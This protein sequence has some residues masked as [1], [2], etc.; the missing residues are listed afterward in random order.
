MRLRILLFVIL[1]AWIN[2]YSQTVYE[3]VSSDIYALLERLYIRGAIEYHSE[4]KP[5]PR[6]EIA[7]YL[8]E[9]ITHKNKLTPLDVKEI[10]FYSQEFADEI[11]F[12][13][14]TSHLQLPRTEFFTSGETGRFRLFNYMDSSFSFNLDPILGIDVASYFNSGYSH[15]WNG[16]KFFGYISDHWGY[17]LDFRDN[18]ES[19]TNIDIIKS[20]TPE[21]GINLT[22]LADK[23]IQYDEVNAE[24]N[25]GWS[26]GNV[27][28]G[29]YHLNIG[30]GRAGQIIMSSKAPSFPMVRL[31]IRPVKW[32]NFIYFHGWLKSDIPDSSTF[33]YTSVKGR[34]SISDVPKFIASHM[35]SFYIAEDLS[36]SIGESVVY[37]GKVEPIY[38][39]PVMFFR[40]ADHYLSSTGS[41]TGDN[42]QI[43]ADASYRISPIKSKVYSSVF[44][45]ELS[46]EEVFKGGNLSS[47][48]YTLGNE[49][50]DLVIPNSSFVIEYTKIQPFVYTNSDDTQTYNSHNYQMGHWAGSNSD[51]FYLS[52]RKNIL[53]GLDVKISGWYFRR[54]QTEEPIQQ[55][56]QPYPPTLY[57]ARRTEK[58]IS[59]LV[60]WQPFHNLYI[61]G[62]YDYSDIS[63]EEEGRTPEFML[64]SYNNFGFSFFYGL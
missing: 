30:N 32:L 34:E 51:I 50:S 62:N 16:L 60:S 44:I 4:I 40:L 48:A 39:I 46:L 54:G 10:E 19:G 6:K 58:K 23:S 20:N 3:P 33:R 38:L 2:L 43:F 1:L 53:R 28:L 8:L 56:Q 26:F 18:L 64:G 17:S 47:I 7:G 52:Y 59:L 11:S 12:I 21:T 31:D 9:A 41:N 25:Y 5:I 55:Y 37:S 42:A 22:K 36:L 49:F 57:G 24:V 27:S 35:L 29:K 15:T 63:D 14:N 13:S 61:K 45:D